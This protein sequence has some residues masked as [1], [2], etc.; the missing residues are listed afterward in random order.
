MVFLFSLV[1]V[2]TSTVVHK[3]DFLAIGSD[4]VLKQNGD[5][6]KRHSPGFSGLFYSTKK[7]ETACEK[8]RC[9]WIRSKGGAK[10]VN[11]CEKY[12]PKLLDRV[13]GWYEGQKGELAPFET[14]ADLG[15]A[16]EDDGCVW[17]ISDYTVGGAECVQGANGPADMEYKTPVMQVTRTGAVQLHPN[18]GRGPVRLILPKP[19]A[20]KREPEDDTEKQTESNPA[21]N[22]NLIPIVGNV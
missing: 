13:Q 15:L 20:E 18:G 17:K 19:L 7:D 12:T 16:C 6:C 11:K 10:C 14:K 1:A 8:A 5:P 2:T 22:P 9:D 4:Q 3:H 21:D